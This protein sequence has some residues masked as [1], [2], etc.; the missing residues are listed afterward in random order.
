M[1]KKA[2][3]CACV[4]SLGTPLTPSLLAAPQTVVVPNNTLVDTGE[5]LDVIHSGDIETSGKVTV[6][7]GG[8]A[9]FVSSTKIVLKPA[10]DGSKGFWAIPN[11]E[12]SFWA[13]IDPDSDG[14]GMTD[15]W[16]LMNG[17]DPENAADAGYDFDDDG[18]SNI[19]EFQNGTNAMVNDNLNWFTEPAASFQSAS[20]SGVII[21]DPVGVSHAVNEIT[22]TVQ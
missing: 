19:F 14:D 15:L 21:I 6:V 2:I 8:D 4:F 11:D 10:A 12:G 3:A 16:E 22:F 18:N 13:V 17:L 7:D 9:M 5:S 20:G 1:K